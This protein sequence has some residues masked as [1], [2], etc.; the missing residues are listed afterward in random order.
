MNANLQDLYEAHVFGEYYANVGGIK[1]T[2]N[3]KVAIRITGPMLK[4]GALSVIK[5]SVL[6]DVLRAQYPDYRRFRTHDI[7]KV[8]NL[9]T[10]KQVVELPLMNHS[11]L[12][13]LVEKKGLP[14]NISLFPKA[15]ELR[16]AIRDVVENREAFLENQSKRKR[17]YGEVIQHKHNIQDLNAHL[18]SGEPTPPNPLPSQPATVDADSFNDVYSFQ[19]DT[20][21]DEPSIVDPSTGKTIE[22]EYSE[23]TLDGEHDPVSSLLS[24]IADDL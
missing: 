17:I 10:G 12:V 6:H 15:P 16:Q 3:Y 9:Q 7:D 23:V 8:I 21:D 1:S 20:P 5:N 13:K 2:K 11:Q 22:V 24:G 14:I 18:I 4:A 19:D